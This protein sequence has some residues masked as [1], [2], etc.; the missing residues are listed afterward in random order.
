MISLIHYISAKRRLKESEKTVMMMGGKDE[1]PPMIQAQTE[2]IQL[3]M[4]YYRDEVKNLIGFILV[5]IIV[6]GV[7]GAVLY[8][9]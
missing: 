7:F 8:N 2:M 9:M 6:V 4:E 5:T 3:E 1:C